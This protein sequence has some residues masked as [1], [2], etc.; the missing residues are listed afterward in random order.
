MCRLWRLW[1]TLVA[2]Y[3][4]HVI[5]LV[6]TLLV[7][8]LC[9]WL[10]SAIYLSLDSVFPAF[11]ERHK[12]QP[13]P[14]QP[15]AAEIRDCL[16]IVTRNQL[17]SVVLALANTAAAV[18]S[19]KPAPF[20]VTTT[21]P[22]MGEFLWELVLCCL[23]RETLFY[24]AHR[25]LHTRRLYQTIHKTHHKFTAPVAFAAQ[26]AHPLEHLLANTLPIALPPVLLHSNVLTMWVFLGLML[27]ETSTVHSGYD[28]FKGAARTHD[29]HHEKFNV[30]YGA[31][32]LLDWIHGTDGSKK[33]K[34]G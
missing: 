14:K 7:Q 24:Y 26:Y 32:G 19:G 15:T 12:L 6:G 33:M 8:V 30:H 17:I 4:A 9:F 28:F 2:T 25:L 11:S 16:L 1:A 23:M 27:V 3:D 20:R 18:A 21:L 22:P 31:I 10:P 29:A 5:E 34:R 13:A